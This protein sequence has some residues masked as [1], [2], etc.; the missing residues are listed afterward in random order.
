M[1][2]NLFQLPLSLCS[3]LVA[4]TLAAEAADRPADEVACLAGP[5]RFAL[6]RDDRGLPDAWFNRTLPQQISLPGAL[7]SQGFGDVPSVDTHWT[8]DIVDRSWF[9]D[10]RMAKYRQPGNVKMPFWL[11]P[12]R[13]YTGAAWYQ[14][15]VEIPAAWS[16]KR[17]TLFLER[18]HW[19]TQ[20]WLD[21]RLLGRQDS[22]ATPHVH[23]L[24]TS[25][26]PGK[27]R[28]TLRVDNRMIVE[29]GVNAHSVSDHTQGNWNGV[30]GRIELR[31]TDPVWID[32][33]T[34]YP[35]VAGKRVRVNVVVGNAGVAWPTA[36]IRP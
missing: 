33:V 3:C 32:R 1:P 20:A 7:Q 12:D 5:W 30:V 27:H 36:S 23:E 24:G 11:Q 14:R 2:M 18:C 21:D 16:G 6:D 28:L 29:V 8:G 17:V 10:P 22:L 35:D 4:F 34:V 9:T 15:D 19:E 31:A 26:A 25:L 13:H